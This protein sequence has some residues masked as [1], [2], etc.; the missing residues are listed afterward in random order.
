[1]E[2]KYFAK[3]SAPLTHPEWKKVRALDHGKTVETEELYEYW[4][5]H[6]AAAVLSDT[7]WM[8]EEGDNENIALARSEANARLQEA[9]AAAGPCKLGK[10]VAVRDGDLKWFCERARAVSKRFAGTPVS[11]VAPRVTT[12]FY[13]PLLKATNQA[14]TTEK[15]QPKADQPMVDQPS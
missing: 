5:D 9:F 2:T 11:L 1:M 8:G 13:M 15:E 3:P 7:W 12:E 6:W 10:V 14:P 4:F